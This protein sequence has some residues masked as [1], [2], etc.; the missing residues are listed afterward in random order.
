MRN[1]RNLLVPRSRLGLVVVLGITLWFST[2]P[3]EEPISVFE[4]TGYAAASLNMPVFY[5]KTDQKAVALTF[6]ISWGTET[7]SLVLAVLERMNQ[8]ATFFLSGPWSTRYPDVVKAIAN[9]G[10]EIASHG[11]KHI[12]LSQ[13]SREHIAD[14][15]TKAHDALISVCGAKARFFRPPNGDYDDL[16]VE[17]ALALGYETVIWSVDSLDWKNPGVATMITRVTKLSFPGAIIL[18]HASDSSKETHLALPEVITALRDAGYRIVTLGELWS[19]GEPG[20]D[21]PRGRP[22]KP[23]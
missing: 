7:P 16:V 1:L 6:D 18:F 13:V 2:G 3:R 19:M 4:N 8:K 14:N 10:H 15:I 11:D 23:N 12:N 22:R 17:T 5:V 21:D 9:A 20:R